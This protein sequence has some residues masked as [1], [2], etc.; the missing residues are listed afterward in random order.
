LETVDP[1]WNQFNHKSGISSGEGL[2]WKVR[3]PVFQ[4]ERNKKLGIVEEV[5]IDP[6]VE[7]KRLLISE[8]EFARV[9]RVMSREGNTLSEVLRCAWDHRNLETMTK[10]NPNR[11]T[12]P[13]ISIIGHITR[14]ELKRELAECDLFN[15]F[16]NRFLWVLNRRSKLLPHGGIVPAQESASLARV[17]ASRLEEAKEIKQMRFD[18]AAYDHWSA[19]YERLTADHPSLYG[20]VISRSEA[21]T[22]R[23]A[24]LYALSDAS[25]LITLA[26]LQ[27]ALAFW[28][29]CD[30]SARILF[31]D[32]LV[33][34]HAQK[35]LEALRARPA[36]MTRAQ[37]SIEI[38]QRNLPGPALDLALKL[39]EKLGL[40]EKRMDPTSR[41][42][43]EV[44][45]IKK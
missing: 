20:Q 33:N 5:M 11:A 26:H 34:P 13:H 29:Y 27:A 39:L 37:I 16:A 8:H 23:L 43:S 10:N 17:L 4:H 15:G 19:I 41:R 28:S 9:L 32:R 25:P 31:G 14:E 6:G 1:H 44:W 24:M 12:N 30:Q 40:A 18:Q 2:I 45:T 38:F 21:Q 22:M 36:G 35:I 42:P 3:D 7:D